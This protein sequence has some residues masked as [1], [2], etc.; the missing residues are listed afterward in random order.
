MAR[1]MVCRFGMS[2]ALGPLTFGRSDGSR[3]LPW[4]VD[5]GETRNFSDETAHLIDAEVKALVETEHQRARNVLA[6]QRSALDAIA[7]ELL[8]HE[9]LSRSEIDEI[10]RHPRG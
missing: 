8:V 10:L 3:F 5:L 7:G 6:A 4:A 1:Q 9:T 2:E